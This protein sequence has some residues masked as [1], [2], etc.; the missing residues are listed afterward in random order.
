MGLFLSFLFRVELAPWLKDRQVD[1][2]Q[3][4]TER[5]SSQKQRQE[6]DRLALSSAKWKSRS[7]VPAR[8]PAGRHILQSQRKDVWPRRLRSRFFFPP[9]SCSCRFL[10]VGRILT[11]LV[12]GVSWLSRQWVYV[13]GFSPPCFPSN[14]R[15][16][17]DRFHPIVLKKKEND[18]KVKWSGN[19]YIYIQIP[20]VGVVKKVHFRCFLLTSS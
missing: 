10:C 17:I 19:I 6:H 7:F 3:E 13:V 5:M 8:A 20:G 15:T 2:P 18:N 16:P 14:L 1:S 4:G 9:S 11:C 12:F